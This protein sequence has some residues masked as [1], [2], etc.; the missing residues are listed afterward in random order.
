MKIKSFN[1]IKLDKIEPFIKQHKEKLKELNPSIKDWTKYIK[2]LRNDEIKENKKK[3]EKSKKEN[4]SEPTTP[5]ENPPF[6]KDKD[7]R[8]EDT[9]P[10]NDKKI[11]ELENDIMKKSKIKEW[12]SLEDFLL[13]YSDNREDLSQLEDM[14]ELSG[15]YQNMIK[16]YLYIWKLKY[17]EL[18]S[19][20]FSIDK[21]ISEIKDEIKADFSLK[22]FDKEK[23]YSKWVKKQSSDEINK[24]IKSY[25]IHIKPYFIY[26]VDNDINL[27][28]EELRLELDDTEEIEDIKVDEEPTYAPESPIILPEEIEEIKE[29]EGPTYVP[30]SPKDRKKPYSYEEQVEIITEFYK[31]VD[32]SKTEEECRGIVNRRRN[33]GAPIG[34]RIPTK[35]WLELCEK[36]YK[37]YGPHPLSIQSLKDMDMTPEEIFKISDLNKKTVS[38]HRKGFVD[39]IN[40]DFYQYLQS[41]ENDSPLNIYQLLVQ[42]YLAVETPYR[43]LLVYHGLGTGK[44]ATAISLA[45][46]LSSQMKINTMLPASLRIEFI[47]EIQKWGTNE[48]NKDNTWK[49]YSLKTLLNE[50]M[51]ED[52]KEKYLIDQ[53]MIALIVSQS[54]RELQK[55]IIQNTNINDHDKEISIMKE[56]VK[57]LKGIWLPDKKGKLLSDYEKDKLD[58]QQYEKEMILQQINLLIE[59]KY[60]FIHYNPF[61]NFKDKKGNAYE[62]GEDEENEDQ[63]LQEDEIEKLNTHNQKLVSQFD[64][65]LKHNIKKYNIDSPF[66]KEVIVI[67]EVHNLVRA[68]LNNRKPAKIMYDWIVNAVDVKLVFLSGT[69]VINKPSEIAILYNML[70][71]LIHI[72]HFTIKTTMKFKDIDK[73]LNELFYDEPT[74]IELFFIQEKKGKII[75]SVIQETSGFESL[76]NKEKNIV[77][78][79]KNNDS[80]FQ[81]F[82]DV[83]YDKLH[84]VFKENDIS[85][86]KEEY[87]TLTEK[88]MK[89]IIRGKKRIFDTDLNIVFNQKQTLFT[90]NEENKNIDMTNNDNFM[91]Y[92]FESTLK[93]PQRKRTLL[94]RMLMG[95][96]T[97]YPIDRSNIVDMPTV[98][99]PEINHPMYQSYSIS[100]QMNIVPCLM[101]QLQFEKYSSWWTAE[102]SMDLFK[103][104]G[105]RNMYN[106]GDETHHYQIRTRQTCNMVYRNEDF[107]TDADDIKEEEKRK[108][109]NS[110]LQNKSLEVNEELNILSPKMFQ[111]MKHMDKFMKQTDEGKVPTGKILFY[112][113]FRSDSGSEAFELVLKANGYEKFDPMKPQTT[114]KKRYTF[115]TGSESNEEKRIS[116]AYFND[117]NDPDKKNKYGEYIQIM[118]ITS[119]GAEGISLS[120]VR[121]VHILE[122]YWNYVRINQVFGRAIRMKSHMDL[123]KENRNVEQYIYLSMI[124]KGDNI[125]SV[126]NEIK[127]LVTWNIPDLK[128]E[129]I[130]SEIVKSSNRSLKE[131]IDM[132]IKINNDSNNKTADQLLFD[133]MER[134]YNIST[135]INDIIKEASL[136]CIPHTRDDP[137]LN[138]KCI[139][140]DNKLINEIA[141]FPGMG[142]QTIEQ[143]DT[144]QLKTK[145]YHVKPDFYVVGATEKTTNKNIYIYYQL[146]TDEKDIDIRYLRQNAKRI[147]DINIIENVLYLYTNNNHEYNDK[148]GKEFSI[149]QEIYSISEHIYENFIDKDTFLHIDKMTQKEQLYGYK[150]KDNVY[151]TYYFIPQEIIHKNNSI[152]RMCLFDEYVNNSYQYHDLIPRVIYNGKLYIQDISQ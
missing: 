130:K 114:K 61:P 80:T 84:K 122:P 31:I 105:G 59:K 44:T 17:K 107:R 65:K 113:D 38:V 64:K 87:E 20:Q 1:K 86:S 68:I 120:C 91:E 16:L 73:K 77:Y 146:D 23:N 96:T 117:E 136:D 19:S 138:D 148:L 89:S 111:I 141:Y 125:Q 85:P 21:R 72:Y 108:V 142:L 90:M 40:N 139:R 62:E 58:Y 126:Y 4:V 7:P 75:F 152:L 151:S 135:E 9:S 143:V 3:K 32:P 33:I 30:G 144:I 116:K 36:L 94:K 63:F 129:D 67:D 18:F 131:L 79:I 92:F 81:Q 57:E 140:F 119:S 95:L 12:I 26:L 71:G 14:S 15:R 101:S 29:D 25:G 52:I 74:P 97:Y 35:P 106:A 115:I 37:K 46:G 51:L 137:Y 22:Y 118:I 55:K 76:F 82:I 54:Q 133:I 83:I 56:K 103:R 27:T 102:K 132:I 11:I 42:K 112:S 127:D 99:D 45:E 78:T 100:N 48:L 147:A 149:Y 5:R 104:L 13:F 121:Q 39:W 134:K 124:P 145:I 49:Y 28:T 2:K 60:N 66:Y 6:G 41:I 109:Y 50:N 53:K 24:L 88:D 43:G 128:T 10:T 47:K 8:L 70:K 98:I 34:T 150:L 110:L 123:L 93:I 69:P